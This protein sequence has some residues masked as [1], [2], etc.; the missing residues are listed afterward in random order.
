MTVIHYVFRYQRRD[1]DAKN[2]EKKSLEYQTEIGDLK[3]KL[4][5]ADNNRQYAEEEAAVSFKI[6]RLITGQY[7]YLFLMN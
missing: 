5:D 7:S 1:R 3:A 2:A 4:N 6:Q